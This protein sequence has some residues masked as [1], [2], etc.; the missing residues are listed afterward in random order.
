MFNYSNYG[1]YFGTYSQQLTNEIVVKDAIGNLKKLDSNKIYVIDSWNKGCGICFKKF[2]KFD[3]LKEKYENNT[4][5]EFIGLNFYKKED[6]ILN[7]QYLFNSKDLNFKTYYIQ[8]NEAR[9]LPVTFFPTVLVL[10]N[11]KIIF[12]GHVETLE[13]FSNYYLK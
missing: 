6:E 5:I 8:V 13:L 1:T 12:R 3:K 2:P 7:S 11:N 10:K 4:N 9:Q